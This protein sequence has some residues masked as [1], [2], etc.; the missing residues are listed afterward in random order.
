M[1]LRDS[2]TYYTAS[3]E[4]HASRGDFLILACKDTD[5]NTKALYA[6]VR[7]VAMSQLGHFMMGY[8]HV[9]GASLVM[10]GQYGS[11]GLPC[12]QH[13]DG[14]TDALIERFFVRVPQAI[15][16]EYWHGSNGSADATIRQWAMTQF[17]RRAKN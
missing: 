4:Q 7:R 17:P 5:T 9:G 13:K 15:A 8:A 16:D 12:G 1:F 2:F 11:D 14:L 3:G 6:T 10:S